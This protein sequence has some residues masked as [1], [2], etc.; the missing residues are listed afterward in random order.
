[1]AQKI[2]ASSTFV[3]QWISFST[4][5]WL[6]NCLT[7]YVVSVKSSAITLVWVIYMVLVKTDYT[8]GLNMSFFIIFLLSFVKRLL[9]N[10]HV[11]LEVNSFV[12]VTVVPP[13]LRLPFCFWNVM[14]NTIKHPPCYFENINT[15]LSRHP[16]RKLSLYDQLFTS[17]VWST[18][19]FSIF[20]RHFSL[21][22][23]SN[24]I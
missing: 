21:T 15:E 3:F 22:F 17:Y 18:T 7:S 5:L 9:Y 19:N 24:V 2:N 23:V 6:F 20:H 8:L 13:L 12:E 14:M 4:P 1:M 16:T 10:L 11:K